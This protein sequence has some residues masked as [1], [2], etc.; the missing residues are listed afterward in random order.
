VENKPV[1]ADLNGLKVVNIQAEYLL[2][3]APGSIIL[4]PWLISCLQLE[5]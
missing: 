4:T 2:V 5:E 3:F 1:Q